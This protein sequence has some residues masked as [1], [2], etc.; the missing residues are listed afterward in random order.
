MV[1]PVK[2]AERLGEIDRRQF[3]R[4]VPREQQKAQAKGLGLIKFKTK[5]FSTERSLSVA[6]THTPLKHG[7][8]SP[9][10]SA[11]TA[12]PLGNQHQRQNG[13]CHCDELNCSHGQCNL[14]LR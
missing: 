8:C 14:T 2:T 13:H 7:D 10:A 12:I 1:S 3:V 4:F 5:I 6:G 11:A 9:I